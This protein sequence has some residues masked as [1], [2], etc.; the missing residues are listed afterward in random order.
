MSY[1]AN[2]HAVFV[3][4]TISIIHSTSHVYE[5]DKNEICK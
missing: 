1:R 5:T 2:N 4:I 3:Q